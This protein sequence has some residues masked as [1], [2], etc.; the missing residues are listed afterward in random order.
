ML[1]RTQD[2]PTQE[3]QRRVQASIAMEWPPPQCP[4]SAKQK[5]S[6][7]Q[8]SGICAPFSERSVSRIYPPLFGTGQLLSGPLPVSKKPPL[9]G[10]PGLPESLYKKGTPIVTAQ[11]QGSLRS[12]DLP[13]PFWDR[14]ALSGP[15]PVSKKPPRARL[16]YEIPIGNRGERGERPR[17]RG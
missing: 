13:P 5:K 12:A 8:R 3:R 11:R 7:R 9:P 6:P 1:R 17:D 10:L 4:R 15:S 2:R 14:P 16:P